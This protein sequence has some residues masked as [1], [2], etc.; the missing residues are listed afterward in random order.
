M[1]LRAGTSGLA[2]EDY[3]EGRGTNLMQFY[4]GCI[5]EQSFS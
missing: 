1:F 5:R 2:L 4:S 3:V